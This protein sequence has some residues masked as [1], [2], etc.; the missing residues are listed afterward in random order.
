L[1]TRISQTAM[2]APANEGLWCAAVVLSQMNGK[3]RSV[4]Q[5][6]ARFASWAIAIWYP[7]CTFAF[8]TL[9]VLAPRSSGL[10][11]REPGAR[12]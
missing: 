3:L 10:G 1:V 5:Q 8:A 12:N 2:L 6:R 4:R 7:A 11:C 9:S